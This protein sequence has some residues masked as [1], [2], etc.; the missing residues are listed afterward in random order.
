MIFLVDPMGIGVV[1][2]VYLI[3]GYTDYAVVYHVVKYGR[4]EERWAE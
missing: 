1:V 4:Q 3:L 2:V